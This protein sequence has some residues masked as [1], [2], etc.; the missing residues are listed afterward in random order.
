MADGRV[1]SQCEQCGQVDDHPKAHIT[2]VDGTV[3]SVHHDC[4]SHSERAMVIGSQGD[5]AAEKIIKACE[6]GKRG[7]DLLA[8]IEKT[9]ASK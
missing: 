2:F 7:P 4:L 3:K 1:E 9:G 8:V 6:G 5:H